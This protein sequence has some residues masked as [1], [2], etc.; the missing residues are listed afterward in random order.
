MSCQQCS[1]MG[2]P[3]SPP[4]FQK[5]GVQLCGDCAGVDP[6]DYGPPVSTVDRSWALADPQGLRDLLD[7][8]D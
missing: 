3:S 1:D 7:E 8:E 5:N 6:E 4:Y 2:E